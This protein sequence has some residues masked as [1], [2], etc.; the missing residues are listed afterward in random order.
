MI[1]AS[2]LLSFGRYREKNTC[3]YIVSCRPTHVALKYIYMYGT[4][5]PIDRVLYLVVES[6]DLVKLDDIRM[7]EHLH[8]LQLSR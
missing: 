6:H 7:V 8:H 4:S 2:R 1:L 5:M 3:M